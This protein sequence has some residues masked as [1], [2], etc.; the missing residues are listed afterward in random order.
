MGGGSSRQRCMCVISIWT[1]ML[2]P[3]GNKAAVHSSGLPPQNTAPA[4]PAD[5]TAARCQV[6]A[7]CQLTDAQ[8]HTLH[9]LDEAL[10]AHR[11]AAAAPVAPLHCQP[12]PAPALQQMWCTNFPIVTN[13]T[14]A[15]HLLKYAHLPVKSIDATQLP[16]E[17]SPHLQGV[18]PGVQGA[19]GGGVAGLPCGSAEGRQRGEELEHRQR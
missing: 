13:Q 17:S 8:P 12:Q 16:T 2:V 14:A 9:A 1:H 10:V 11:H 5:C 7:S 19:V 3:G 15:K 4:N 6:A 18:R